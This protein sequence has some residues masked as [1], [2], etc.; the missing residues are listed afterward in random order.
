MRSGSSNYVLFSQGHPL[1]NSELNPGLQTWALFLLFP[2]TK[3]AIQR[4][5]LMLSYIH[6]GP[7]A[8]A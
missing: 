5:T 4:E 8:H 6:I 3:Q 2:F 7:K 1:V